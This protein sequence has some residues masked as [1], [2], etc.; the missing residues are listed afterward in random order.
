[1][2]NSNPESQSQ[3][4]IPNTQSQS[5]ILIPNSN[6]Q[7]LSRLPFLI[8]NPQ[9]QIPIFNPNAP[10]E[11]T[12]LNPNLLCLFIY[13]FV[14][15]LKQEQKLACSTLINTGAHMGFLYGTTQSRNFSIFCSVSA[16]LL[17]ILVPN[18]SLYSV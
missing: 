14:S 13:L 18:I 15:K 8:P 9:S 3:I 7:S 1:M 6:P 12:I 5:L 17:S 2:S 16:M 11:S 4:L 10:F